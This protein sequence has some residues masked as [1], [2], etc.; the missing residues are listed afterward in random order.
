MIVCQNCQHKNIDGTM[1]CEDCGVQIVTSDMMSTQIISDGEKSVVEE[2][3]TDDLPKLDDNINTWGSLHLIESGQILPLAERSEFT[4]GRV[5]D[6]QAIMPDID[7][8]PYKAYSSGVSRLHTVILRE[9]NRI[10]IMDLGSAN[11]TYLNGKRLKANLKQAL[12]HG[13]MISLGKL[14]IQVLL[15]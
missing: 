3:D 11:G 14:K 5:T 8:T 1:F 12:S 9:R 2:I 10:L 6:S 4:L 7:L 15:N 13:D